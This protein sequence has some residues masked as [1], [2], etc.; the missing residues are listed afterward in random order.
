MHTFDFHGAWMNMQSDPVRVLLI[1][2]DEDDYSVVRD[3]LS[4]IS[5]IECILK[6]VS[7]YGAHWMQS[8]P[9]SSMS[10]CWTAGSRSEMGWNS[11]KR[12]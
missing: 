11:C 1:D 8:F 4:H 3:L 5:A 6:W 10:A 9:V 7:G 2:D 12:P